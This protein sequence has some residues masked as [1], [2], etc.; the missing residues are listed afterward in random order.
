MKKSILLLLLFTIT[1]LSTYGQEFTPQEKSIVGI[2]KAEGKTKANIF[3]F[4]NKWIAINYNSAQNVIQMNDKESGDIIVKGINKATYKNIMKDLYPSNKYLP[5][6]NTLDFNHTL[7][8]NVKDDKYR[9]TYTLTDII[10]PQELAGYNIDNQYNIIFD[11]ID[12]TGLKQDK[13]HEY[14]LFIEDWYRK[15]LIGKKKRAKAKELTVPIYEEMIKGASESMKATMQ[16]I[17][18]SVNLKSNDDW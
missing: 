15:A 14:N 7:E 11:M 13:V 18:K 12:F 9:V 2:F 16:S 1:S 8:I 3:A 6:Y 10:K 5:D 17:E 4:V